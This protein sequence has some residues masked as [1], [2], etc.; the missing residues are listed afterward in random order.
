VYLCYSC[1]TTTDFSPRPLCSALH[2][3]VLAT[4][5]RLRLLRARPPLPEARLHHRTATEEREEGIGR[6]KV[7]L[8]VCV[9]VCAS[10]MNVYFYTL[11]HTYTHTQDEELDSDQ[12]SAL[13]SESR[14]RGI[15]KSTA[16]AELSQM[17]ALDPRVCA[18]CVCVFCVCILC[19]ELLLTPYSYHCTHTHTQTPATLHPPSHSHT[20][21]LHTHTH[22]YILHCT[23][24]AT[25]KDFVCIHAGSIFRM[26][27]ERFVAVPQVCVCV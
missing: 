26:D 19:Y 10:P 13:A 15:K 5:R 21:A 27:L 8:C 18:Y 7:V 4:C 22:I 14:F 17:D 16:L 1:L 2:A 25:F 3:P 9:C 23:Q 12:K 11:T 20:H 24:V 6:C